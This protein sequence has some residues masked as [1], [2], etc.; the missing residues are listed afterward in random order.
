MMGPNTAPLYRRSGRV[1]AP[2]LGF[3]TVYGTIRRRLLA[4]V[5]LGALVAAGAMLGGCSRTSKSGEATNTGL[6]T[7]YELGNEQDFAD[8]RKERLNYRDFD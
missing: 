5:A 4:A 2:T 6:L 8:Q 7:G 1:G 3:H